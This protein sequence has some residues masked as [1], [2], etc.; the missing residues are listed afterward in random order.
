MATLN[1][2][3]QSMLETYNALFLAIATL[4][5]AWCTYQSTLW[6]GIQT[7][8]LADS[9]KYGRP[10][11]QNVIQAGQRIAMDEA[12]IITFT[13][14]VLNKNQQRIN[15][16]LKGTGE[17]SAVMSSW[18]NKYNA[19]DTNGPLHPMLTSAYRELVKT[20]MQ[21]S[22]KMS[23]KGAEFYNE[24]NRA[25]RIADNYTIFTVLFSMVMFL[26]AIETKLIRTTP[27]IILTL[28]SAIICV[29]VLMI[30]IFSMPFAHR[31]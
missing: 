26:S 27:K 7:F 13:D 4:S 18:M 12:V 16:I 14:A 19:G 24:A 8:R 6:N 21:E 30:V 9:N 5:M 25:N 1:D 31:G 23:K 22:E 15:F 28:I 11:Q 10:A 29:S 2:L 3:R 20:R 17:L